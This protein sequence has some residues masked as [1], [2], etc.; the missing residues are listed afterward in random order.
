MN[1]TETRKFKKLSKILDRKHQ[2]GLSNKD[3]P[4]FINSDGDPSLRKSLRSANRNKPAQKLNSK[5]RAE[6]MNR[7]YN[8]I[9]AFVKRAI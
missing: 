5:D 3:I 9:M 1:Y 4:A 2:G 7:G 6:K 8:F